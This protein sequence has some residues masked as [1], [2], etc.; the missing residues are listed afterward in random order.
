M[1]IKKVGIGLV[2]LGTVGSGLVEI[3][4]KKH[5]LFKKKYNLDLSI[6]GISARSKTK[7][8]SFNTNKYV[9]FQDPLKMINNSKID[10]IVEL[11]GGSDGL[12]L[13]LAKQSLKKGKFF[14]TAN[15][16]LIAKHGIN[17][18]KI[19]NRYSSKFS[20]EAAVGGGVPI[21]RVLQNSM[22]VGNTKNIYGILNGTCNYILT[23][24]KENK[25]S[26]K[27]ALKDAQKLGFA[28]AD[29]HDDISGTDTAYKLSILSNL[30]FNINSKF[31]SIYIEG[32]QS[33]EDIDINMS[34]QLGY[35]IVLLGIANLKNNKVMQRV[36][37]CM[38]PNNSM[39]A[40]VNNEL[41]TVVI[42]DE[43]T[44]KI[45][46]VGKGAGKSPT[47]A[48]VISDIL[49]IFDEKKINVFFSNSQKI[50]KLMPQVI[51]NREGRFYIRMGV[52]D[53]P[54]VLADITLFFKKKKISIKSMFQLDDKIKNLVPLIFVTHKVTE[55]KIYS[56]LKKMAVLDIIK[57][58]IN[59][60]RIEEL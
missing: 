34:D 44:D 15:K 51:D 4:Q 27:K 58:K 24:M 2:G 52:H 32:I 38:I 3:I 22:I 20:F 49:N 59:L 23:K 33:I 12:A 43:Y 29:P 6:Q 14:V 50:K 16:A 8:R 47:A 35:R 39:L 31:S 17:M 1:N 40:K 21:I 57:T 55:K 11:I 19:S 53:K 25:I 13:E 5:S 60:I 9:W 46:I 26:F 45:M 30:V 28:E 36:H 10:I 56:V 41:N 54:G 42:D 18:F 7:V 37:P 48:S